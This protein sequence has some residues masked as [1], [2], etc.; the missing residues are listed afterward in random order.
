MFKS[1]TAANLLA[2]CLSTAVCAVARLL[3]HLHTNTSL[4]DWQPMSKGWGGGK[5]LKDLS[6]R[7]LITLIGATNILFELSCH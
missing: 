6:Y 3:T 1:T 2:Y 4:K 5:M 7:A